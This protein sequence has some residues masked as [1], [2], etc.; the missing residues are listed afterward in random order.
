[1][2]LFNARTL[3]S[4]NLSNCIKPPWFDMASAGTGCACPIQATTATIFVNET[5]SH[6]NEKSVLGKDKA[7]NNSLYDEV[8]RTFWEVLMKEFLAGVLVVVMALVLSG[9]GVLLLPLLLVLGIFLRLAI[10]LI[11]LL[12]AIWLIGKVTLFLF[13]LLRKKENNQG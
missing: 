8:S 7:Y 9:I 13:D 10:G 3:R 12:L 1:M 6:Y 4:Y 11:V 5:G 2:I